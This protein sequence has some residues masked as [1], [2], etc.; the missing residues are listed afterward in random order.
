M[1]KIILF[2][3]LLGILQANAQPQKPAILNQSAALL[4]K[5]VKSKLTVVEKNYLAQKSKL[6]LSPNKKKFILKD[7]PESDYEVSVYPVD[8]NKDGIEELFI[9]ENSFF[10]GQGGG[11]FTLYIKDLKGVYQVAASSSGIPMILKTIS[12]GFPDLLVGGAGMELPIWQY[13]GKIYSYKKS[14]QDQSIKGTSLEDASAAYSKN[15]K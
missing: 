5:G 8:L 10:F 12:V 6:T 15:L 4:F 13:N 14:T 9:T 2:A 7:D 11:P 1:R 3:C